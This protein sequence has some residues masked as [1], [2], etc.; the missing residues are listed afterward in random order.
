MHRPAG[1][2]VNCF[3]SRSS[4]HLEELQ[5]TPSAKE[6][7]QSTRR[8]EYTVQHQTKYDVSPNGIRCYSRWNG[9]NYYHP[10]W[11]CTNPGFFLLL[12][13]VLLLEFSACAAVG[14]G[15]K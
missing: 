13:L 5:I 12:V 2:E 1:T 14:S 15:F 6:R 7:L 4:W 10:I 11:L 8:K 3:R 9:V